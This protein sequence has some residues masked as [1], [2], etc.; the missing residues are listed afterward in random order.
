MADPQDPYF[1]TQLQQ[2]KRWAPDT[3]DVPCI[4]RG[5]AS[6]WSSKTSPEQWGLDLEIT[7]NLRFKRERERNYED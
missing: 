2:P 4:L 6:R 5:S 1:C 3:P 7:I